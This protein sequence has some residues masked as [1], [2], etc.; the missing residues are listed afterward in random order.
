MSSGTKVGDSKYDMEFCKELYPYVYPEK[1]PKELKKFI[2]DV[3]RIGQVH[4]GIVW[5][6]ALEILSNGKLVQDK[7]DG[8]GQDFTDTSDGKTASAT[9]AIE[10]RTTMGGT[11]LRTVLD[12]KGNPVLTGDIRA[13][14]KSA[15]K[16]GPLRLMLYVPPVKRFDYFFIPKSYHKSKKLLSIQYNSHGILKTKW[17]K[18]YRVDSKETLANIKATAELKVTLGTVKKIIYVPQKTYKWV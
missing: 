12:V 11:T 4:T 18:Q 6:K 3:T 8:N 13:R 1:S 9:D 5:E 2:K 15:G 10:K 7:E 16:I 17:A 14:I